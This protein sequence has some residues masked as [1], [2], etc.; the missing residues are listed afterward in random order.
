MR[1]RTRKTLAALISVTALALGL[2]TTTA[3]SASAASGCWYS[4]SHWWC[5][6]RAGAPVYGFKDLAR[7]YPDSSRIVGYMNSNPSW[8]NCRYDGGASDEYVGGPHPYRW[9]W[10]EA[11]NG[12]WGWMKDTA[13]S[14]ETNP[15][16][17]CW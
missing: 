7:D 3:P 2:G 17:A 4:G 13:I 8:F 14:S 1:M 15:L 9:E 10:T 16:P 6:N 5:N 12:Q 11:D